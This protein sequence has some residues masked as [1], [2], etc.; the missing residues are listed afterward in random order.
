MESVTRL[1]ANA[2]CRE[3]ILREL[4]EVLGGGLRMNVCLMFIAERKHFFR[5]SEPQMFLQGK[6]VTGTEENRDERE[7]DLCVNYC[8]LWLK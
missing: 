6:R 8:G 3:E 7:R 4:T 1:R 2:D 5:F